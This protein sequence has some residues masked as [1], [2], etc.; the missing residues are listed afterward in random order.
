MLLHVVLFHFLWLSNIP[1]YICTTSFLIHSSVDGH[2]GCFH[3]LAIINSAAMN[4]CVHVSFQIRILSGYILEIGLLDH[5]ATLFLFFEE[6][7]YCS[8]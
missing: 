2:L 6:S 5:M 3:V 4:I 7:P 8:L 1:F